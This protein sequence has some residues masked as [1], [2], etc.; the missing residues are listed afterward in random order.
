MIKRDQIEKEIKE[1]ELQLKLK[2]KELRSLDREPVKRGGSW[3]LQN[4][5]DWDKVFNEFER[6]SIEIVNDP[7]NLKK[8]VNIKP[9]SLEVYGFNESCEKFGYKGVRVRNTFN[10]KSLQ[11]KELKEEFIKRYRESVLRI[12]EGREKIYK[13]KNEKLKQFF[14]SEMIRTKGEFKQVV[15]SMKGM[16][17]F[18]GLLVVYPNFVNE[19]NELRT[20][21]RNENWEEFRRECIQRYEEFRKLGLKPEHSLYVSGIGRLK[22]DQGR[23]FFK[24]EKKFHERVVKEYKKDLD[25]NFDPSIKDWDHLKTQENYLDLIKKIKSTYKFKKG[26]DTGTNR[27]QWNLLPHHF[28]KP[29]YRRIF[30]ERIDV[31]FG[32]ETTEYK[33]IEKLVIRNEK[34][35]KIKNK[36]QR[37][38]EKERLKIGVKTNKIKRDSNRFI[39]N[40]VEQLIR[41]KDFGSKLEKVLKRRKTF[42][43]GSHKT[44]LLE[45]IGV[46]GWVWRRTIKNHEHFKT[47][48]QK[49]EDKILQEHTIKQLESVDNKYSD[50]VVRT[51]QNGKIFY[52]IKNEVVL[53]NCNSCGE[54]KSR[55]NFPIYL[56]ISTKCFSCIKGESGKSRPGEKYKG[57]IIKKYDSRGVVT[58]NRCT[59]CDEFK[60]K[61][62]FKYKWRGSSVCDDC[63]VE[64][65]NNHLTRKGEFDSK[66]NRIRIYNSH[67]NVTHKRCNT[68]NDMK[69]LDEFNKWN[70]SKIDGKGGTCRI[71]LNNSS[72]ELV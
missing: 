32:R 29:D 53:K 20:K 65:P 3:F 30:N 28:V 52:D 58:H 63:Y 4:P 15:K 27:K 44:D 5:Q 11:L 55:D 46:G 66:G 61:K 19:V 48:I 54:T 31:L 51:S 24:D 72:K 56:N 16:G 37:K 45:E 22:D 1:L 12:I 34:Q 64:L 62:Q 50:L 41:D 7:K 49:V 6:I 9:D 10:I 70:G 67:F 43:V 40:S 57:K 18:P 23:D 33:R 17:G 42:K 26:W 13:K 60:L 8:S 69:V 14:I 47:L 2:K 71:C 68:C 39:Y 38:I 36:I 25:D 21:L 35:G 59:S